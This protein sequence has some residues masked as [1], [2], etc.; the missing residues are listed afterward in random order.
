MT[1][2]LASVD[3]PRY[4]L[5]IGACT[6]HQKLKPLL[7]EQREIRTAGAR[8]YGRNADKHHDLIVLEDAYDGL[9]FLEETSRAIPL[10]RPGVDGGC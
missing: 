4:F 1:E 6:D 5:D 2:I 9:I 3:E 7:S 10:A 8:Y